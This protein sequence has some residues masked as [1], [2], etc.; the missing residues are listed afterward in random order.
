MTRFNADDYGITLAQAAHIRQC[1]TDGCLTGVSAMPNAPLLPQAMEAI[2]SD[3]SLTVAVH[4]N[5][6]EGCCLSPAADIPLLAQADG[7]FYPSFF[8]LFALSLGP[9]RKALKAQLMEE[10]TAQIETVRPLLHGRCL[11]LDGHQHIQMIPLVMETIRDVVAQQG[12]PIEAIRYSQ[13]PL[14]PYLRH[15]SLWRDY[16]PVN[17]IKNLVLNLFAWQ[18]RSYMQD[19]GLERGIIMGLVISGNLEYRL[20]SALLPDFQRIAHRRGVD[21]ELVMHPGWGIEPGQGL[22]EPGGI[23]EAFYADPGRKREYQCL[24]S[25]QENK[26]K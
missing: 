7:R 10:I 9:K 24:I 1:R 17:L 13:E 8:R 25:L 3:P 21:L 19:M 11:R 16:R 2:D 22:D 18:D 26:T 14:T 6:T 4:L 15:L 5:M 12:Y 23:F 20:V